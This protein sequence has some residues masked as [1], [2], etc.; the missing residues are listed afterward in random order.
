MKKLLILLSLICLS[1]PTSIFAQPTPADSTELRAF[2]DGTIESYMEENQIAGATLAIIRN[3]QPLM[4][5]G[6]GYADREQRQQVDASTTLFRI[7]SIS[8]L[9]VWTAVMQLVEQGRLDLNADVNQYLE[10]F[11]IPETYPEPITLKHLMTHTA[12]FEDRVIGLFARDSSNVKPLGEILAEELPARVRP[13]GQY[14]SYS[15]HGTGIAAYIVEQ[16]SGLDFQDYVEQNIL[17]PL[18]M[19]STTFRQPLPGYLRQ[20]VSKGYAYEQGEFIEK[21]FEFVPMGPVGTASTTAADMIPFMQAHLNMGRYEGTAILDST[22]AQLMQSR[23]F[24]HAEGVNPM[25]YG[26]IDMSQHG[27]EIFGHGGDTFWFHSTLALF[28]NHNLGFFLSFNSGNGGPITGKVLDEFVERFFPN[29][30]PPPEPLSVDEEY[31]QQFA[32]NYRSNRYPHER[33]TKIIALMNPMSVS[34]TEEGRLKT[35]RNGEGE[36]WIPVESLTFENTES[37]EI[38][39]FEQNSSGEITHLFLEDLP[40]VAFEKV[41]FIAGQELHFSIFAISLVVLALT[42]L[43]WPSAYLIRR[44]YRA[45]LTTTPPLPLYIKSIAWANSLLMLAFY[46]GLATSFGGPENIVYGVAGSI[47]FLLILPIISLILTLVMFYLATQ[48]WKQSISGIWSRLCF[49]LLTLI[50]VIALWQLY[51]WNF[52]GFNY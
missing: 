20:R 35:M 28:P 33:F 32:G 44:K 23:A 46:F 29:D 16:V 8:K 27:I 26:F 6:Y 4:L 7:G 13:P 48:L 14:A 15:N 50:F 39:V 10:D 12:G 34:V 30:T 47:T 18:G 1:K 17:Q 43:Y 25:R 2:M 49:S 24:S 38:M 42:L 36:S 22:T 5:K 37:R 45:S 40:I 41:P 19:S 31:L 52:L 51:Y 9:F 21:P 11:K 3:G